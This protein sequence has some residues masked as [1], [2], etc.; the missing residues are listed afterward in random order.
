MKKTICLVT[1]W[2]PTKENPYQGLF[3]KEQAF[4]VSEYFDFVIV[5]YKEHIRKK[6]F[7]K[8]SVSQSNQEK[9][10]IEYDIDITVPC[11]LYM[12]NIINDFYVK[13]IRKKTVE[14][15]GKYIS[16]KK[17]A[18]TKN[19]ISRVFDQYI[20]RDIDVFYCVDAQQEA[21]NVQCLAEHYKK[22]YIVGE[23][24]P[25]PWPGTVINDVNK[26]AIEK[27]DLF[28]AIS[29]DKIRQLLLQNIKL[30]KIVYLGNLIDETKIVNEHKINDVKTFIIVA[31]HTF[32]K[33]Y[34]LFIDVMNRVTEITD[35]DF[36]VMIVG[37][38]ANKGYSQ[39]IELF[40]NQIKH[41]QFAD[42]AIMIPEVPHEKIGDVLNKADAFIMTSIQ[43]GQP[44]SAMEAAC[45]GLPI[46]STRC[47]GVEDYIDEKMGRI[48]SVTDYE[49]MAQGLKEFL[50]G[51]L[52]F[53]PIYIRKEI[54]EKF[55]VKMFQK[56]FVK[57][58]VDVI[59][60]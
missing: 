26:Y 41:S 25:V 27:A 32:Y 39:N 12:R 2:Y 38:G 21:F 10:T 6:P 20:K 28:L 46:F 13:H 56:K 15:V 48:Y 29:N 58:I 3:F 33:N 22:P 18:Y 52:E 11:T 8:I 16:K 31:A 37:Y 40:E 50:E 51:K 14:G 54:I 42:R 36:N 4:A 60:K 7:S 45:C 30:P 5:H 24:A 53:D 23:H 19:I 44:V 1:N 55:G 47:G 35:C 17:A 9:N 59:M 43:E 34:D 49:G 57:A